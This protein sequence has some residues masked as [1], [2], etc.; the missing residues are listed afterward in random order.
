M[1]L[2]RRRAVCID[3]SFFTRTLLPDERDPEV[4]RQWTALL[5]DDA[6]IVAPTL[7]PWE[8]SNA[9]LQAMRRGRI[10]VPRAERALLDITRARVAL[11]S[12][13][14]HLIYVWQSFVTRYDMPAVYD[15]T[16]LAVAD[17]LG[18]ELWTADRRLYRTVGH[19]LPW[20]VPCGFEG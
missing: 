13:E 14:E 9:V 8:C 15:A 4:D 20:V 10:A 18:C 3:A 2:Q 6:A 19:A 16:Y 17:M 12:I 1:N 7:F 11:V 5:S